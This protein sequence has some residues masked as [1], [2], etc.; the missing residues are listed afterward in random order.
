MTTEIDPSIATQEALREELLQ[1]NSYT[2]RDVAKIVKKHKYT[3]T[4]YVNFSEDEIADFL[5]LSAIIETSHSLQEVA[6]ILVEEIL[7]A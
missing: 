4:L 7:I 1:K 5:D 3:Y 2:A 6:D